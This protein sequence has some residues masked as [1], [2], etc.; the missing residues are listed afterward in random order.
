[1]IGFARPAVAPHILDP[2]RP[3]MRKLALIAVLFVVSCTDPA[4]T[5]GVRIGA[6]GVS[7]V[8]AVS[9]KVGGATVSVS[10]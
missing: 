9:G 6:G 10:P 2:E 8:P 1:M 5:A 3:H 4:L 7:I